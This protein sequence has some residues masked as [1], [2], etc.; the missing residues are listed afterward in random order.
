MNTPLAVLLE[1][2]ETAND[3]GEA[4][5]APPPVVEAPAEKATPIVSSGEAT[6]VEGEAVDNRDILYAQGAV[7]PPPPFDEAAFTDKIECTVR[8]ALRDAMAEE[9]RADDRFTCWWGR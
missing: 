5:A 6:Q 9:M 2:G 1:E 4:P 7:L 3:L 8:V